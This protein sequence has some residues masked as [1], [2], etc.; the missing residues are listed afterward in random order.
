MKESIKRES[1]LDFIRCL[2]LLLAV[3][4]HMY[5]RIDFVDAPQNG[6][7]MLAANSTRIIEFSCIGLFLMLTGYL[8]SE[9]PIN[10]KYFTG[11]VPILLSYAV[12]TGAIYFCASSIL[13][14]SVSFIEMIKKILTFSYYSWYV[15]MYIGLILFSPFINITLK[16]VEKR[17][18]LLLLL[19]ALLILTALPSVTR[20]PIAPDYWTTLYPFTYYV[21]GAVIKRL[22]IKLPPLCLFLVPLIAVPF[23]ALSMWK[24]NGNFS[25]GIRYDYGSF[26]VVVITVIIFLSLYHINFGEISAKIL[27][28]LAGG[29]FEAYLVSFIF[30]RFIYSK[31]AFLHQPKYYF[32]LWMC[33]SVPIF[34]VSL[35][36]GKL[37]N[38]AV[39]KISTPIVKAIVSRFA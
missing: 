37:V 2:A 19:G 9:K 29:V 25:S 15:E 14:M 20:Y 6:I 36:V 33:V 1:G 39:K 24:M 7:F 21:I 26:F 8:K 13:G 18:H 32:I 11:L 23:S 10:V 30:D 34:F 17:K 3:S 16:N 28:F 38:L 22:Q 35:A 27:A 31:V 4:V 12:V 5:L